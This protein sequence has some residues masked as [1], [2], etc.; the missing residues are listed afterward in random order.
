MKLKNDKN[1]IFGAYI[2]FVRLRKQ[3]FLCILDYILDDI[4]MICFHCMWIESQFFINS[5]GSHLFLKKYF[6]N[7][8][9]TLKID[10]VPHWYLSIYAK[11]HFC[12]KGSFWNYVLNHNAKWTLPKILKYTCCFILLDTLLNS[13][14]AM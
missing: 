7:H 5:C 14:F 13:F 11:I 1:D 10:F 2:D 9:N 3:S 12:R 8:P 4:N 6:K